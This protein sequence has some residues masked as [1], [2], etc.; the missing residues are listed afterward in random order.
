MDRKE[1]IINNIIEEMK[2]ATIE[3]GM[4]NEKDI[5]SFVQGQIDYAYKTDSKVS[6]QDRKKLAEALSDAVINLRFGKKPLPD[7]TNPMCIP[8]LDPMYNA[9]TRFVR[10]HQGEKGFICTED[11]PQGDTIWGFVYNGIAGTFD[12][13]QVKAVRVN[14]NGTLQ[15]LT[16]IPNI[17]Y[18]DEAVRLAD[19]HD[20][21]DVRYGGDIL[22]IPTIFSIAESIKQYADKPEETD[23][24]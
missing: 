16:D 8:D 17:L 24:T 21:Q 2:T 5:R 20:W 15:C 19:K 13:M 14:E 3:W 22:Y 12:E 1:T 7:Q 11:L 9:V 18:T 4:N 23:A 10:E 6:P